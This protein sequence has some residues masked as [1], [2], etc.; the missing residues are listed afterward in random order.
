MFLKYI[1][2]CQILFRYTCGV[3][4]Q[5]VIFKLSYLF[6]Y[7]IAYVLRFK[8]SR[9]CNHWSRSFRCYDISNFRF[10]NSLTV[11]YCLQ[12][13]NLIHHSTQT[14][15]NFYIVRVLH[16]DELKEGTWL[17]SFDFHRCFGNNCSVNKLC[18]LSWNSTTVARSI[19]F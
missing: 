13:W 1:I 16:L 5:Q 19:A 10:V 8:L 11:V 14:N 9:L 18:S 3:S 15:L 2:I 7:Q 17:H 12:I 6:L 4:R